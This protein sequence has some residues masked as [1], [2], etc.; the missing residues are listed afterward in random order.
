[1]DPFGWRIAAVV[2]GTLMVL[3]MCRLGA[4]AHRVDA[5]RLHG[6]PAAE[7]R[8]PALR[9][10]PARAARHL[11]GVLPARA[12]SP[13]WSTT[14][15]GTGRSWPGSSRGPVTGRGPRGARCAASSS[16][17]GCSRAA[18]ASASPSGPSGPRS[19]RWRRS[20]CWCGCGAPAP[21]ARSACAAPVRRSA[22][23]DG[24]PAFVPSWCSAA[25]STPPPG[26]GWLVHADEY[27]DALSSTQ[28]TRFSGEGSCGRRDVED[29]NPN[30]D[31]WPTA[32]EQD[33]SGLGEVVQSLR[34]LWYYHQDVFTFHAHFLNCSEHTYASQP[35]GWLLINRPVGV[36]AD[37]D[38][39]P[40][41]QGC[42]APVGSDC[43]RQVLLIGTPVIWWAR[44]PGRSCTPSRCGSA[45]RDWRFGVAV[46]GRG[47]DLAAVAAV[48]RPA[49]LLLLRDRDAAVPGARADAGDRQADRAAP[50]CPRPAA[51]SA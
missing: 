9:A 1:M 43:L 20:G 3:V 45:R 35:S 39:Q 19:S 25:S 49:D 38:I 41:E 23:A 37:T 48:R 51:P 22:V 7:P 24:V 34:S 29:P 42:D 8:R 47:V 46:V 15:T 5:A 12:R 27:E 31:R 18:S 40:G 44:D 10:V 33:A 6:G 16:G 14:A 21:G 30:D 32:R 28:Y 26:P 50:A 4:P 17:P 13:A 2:A 36:A 11:P